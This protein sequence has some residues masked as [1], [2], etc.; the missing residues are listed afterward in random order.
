MKYINAW[1]EG[2]N[3]VLMHKENGVKKTKTMQN[4]DWYFLLKTNDKD[5]YAKFPSSWWIK[6]LKSNGG[7]IKRLVPDGE[8]MRVYID[9]CNAHPDSQFKDDKMKLIEALD[10]FGVV[11]YNADLPSWKLF[12]LDD[13]EFEIEDDLVVAFIDIETDDSTGEIVVG[14]DRILS[15]AAVDREENKIFICENTEKETLLKI[16]EYLNTV[17]VVLGWNSKSFDWPYIQ[18]RFAKYNISFD[19]RTVIHIDLMWRFIK[20]FAYNAQGISFKLNDMAKFFIGE[21]KIEL[22]EKIIWYFDN[23]REKLKKYNLNDSELLYKMDKKLNVVDL[24]LLECKICKS[25]LSRF[26]IGELLD[27]Y[28]LRNTTYKYPSIRQNIVVA[29]HYAGAIVLDPVTGLHKDVFCFDFKSLYPSIIKTW[30]ISIDA[31]T[32]EKEE[33]IKSVNGVY[34][35]KKMGMIPSIITRLLDERAKFKKIQLESEIG[36][37]EYKSAVAHQATLKE[38]SNSMYGILGDQRGRYYNLELAE[39]ITLAGQYLLKT[40]QKYVEDREC[41][42]IA[43][44]TDSLFVKFKDTKTSTDAENIAKEIT[45]YIA[46]HLKKEFN[47]NKSYI[48]LE[49]EKKFKTFIIVAKKRYC[50]ILEELD[51]KAVDMQYARGLENVRKDTTNYQRNLLNELFELLLRKDYKAHEVKKWL[52]DKKEKYLNEQLTADDLK[53][54]I[55][56]SKPFDTYKS[57][58]L[59]IKIAKQLKTKNQEMYI[60]MSIPFIVTKS[61]PKLDGVHVDDFDGKYDI[62]YYWNRK[63]APTLMRVLIEC[64]PKENWNTFYVNEWDMNRKKG[65]KQLGDFI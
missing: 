3:V 64:F 24:M 25:F 48:V 12:A 5:S 21:G 41:T 33:T 55:K 63:F 61:S 52:R 22:D 35:N 60:G 32:K 15:F 2:R 44:D 18:T 38:M 28:I 9:N 27:N 45:E 20:L 39:A 6:L 59:H 26:Y 50:G 19:W 34:F 49:Y 29:K 23:N 8:F 62:K 57:S 17:D 1:N 36:S 42:V 46:E 10:K 11:H 30:N 53:I 37:L 40:T 43:G 4:F 13:K 58:S 31:I 54:A 16:K 47:I 56:I 7:L 65:Q 14:R 51:G